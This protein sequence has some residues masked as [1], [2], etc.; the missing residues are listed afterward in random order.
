MSD[1]ARSARGQSAAENEDS[2]NVAQEDI[3]RLAYVLWEQ[4]GSPIGS[5]EFDWLEAEQQL[6]K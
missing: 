6:R 4:R 1:T 2:G 5:S 3:A